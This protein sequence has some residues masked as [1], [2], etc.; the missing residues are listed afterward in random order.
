MDES[1]EDRVE[2]AGVAGVVEA[3]PDVGRVGG[4]GLG[5]GAGVERLGLLAVDEGGCGGSRRGGGSEGGGG[6]RG[7][8][9]RGG[10]RLVG[11]KSTVSS[12]IIIK[13]SP[14]RR[15][16]E[17]SLWA[18][19]SPPTNPSPQ[20]STRRPSERSPGTPTARSESS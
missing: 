11:S 15:E 6:R 14:G 16:R 1:L 19:G 18:T 4:E 8:L 7:G 12:C 2:V 20:D 5:D 9:V 3:C 13:M 17:S 10:S